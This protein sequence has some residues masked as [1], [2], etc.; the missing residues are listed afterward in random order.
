MNMIER[1]VRQN[2]EDIGRKLELTEG[3]NLEQKSNISTSM[4]LRTVVWLLALI[5]EELINIRKKL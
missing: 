5:L 4:S 2:D 1:I 3:F